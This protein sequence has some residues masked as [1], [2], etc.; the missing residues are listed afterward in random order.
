MSVNSKKKGKVGELEVA[1]I[2]REHGF[3]SQRGQQFKGSP[4][5]PDVTGIDGVHIEVKRVEKLNIT[6]AMEQSRT[7]AGDGEMPVVFHRKNR[8][9]WFVTMDLEDFLTLIKKSK[10]E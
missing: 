6:K 4:D 10:D 7:D 1:K 9:P 2:L 5:S 3:D 8:E